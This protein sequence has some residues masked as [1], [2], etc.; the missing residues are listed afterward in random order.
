MDI[1]RYR[2]RSSGQV[3]GKYYGRR[4]GRE[5]ASDRTPT[6]FQAGVNSVSWLLI[7]FA[8]VMVPVEQGSIPLVLQVKR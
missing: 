2:Q 6:A 4:A 1:V 3:A 8:L 5:T 7:R